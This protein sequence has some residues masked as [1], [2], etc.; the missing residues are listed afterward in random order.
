[1]SEVKIG[2]RVVDPSWEWEFRTGLHY[3]REAGDKNRPVSWIVTAKEHYDKMEPHVTLLSKNLIGRYAFDN[4]TNRGSDYVNNHWGDSGSAKAD[5]ALRPWLNSNGMHSNVSFYMA[6][7]ENFKSVVRIINVAN[8]GWEKGNTYTIEDW[9]FVLSTTEFGDSKHLT[10][11]RPVRIT[12]IFPGRI[13]W[14]VLR[15]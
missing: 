3:T 13:T 11:T 6:F 7:S 2:A 1:M 14:T 10:P 12:L 8:R 9:V 4:S 15:N 5:R